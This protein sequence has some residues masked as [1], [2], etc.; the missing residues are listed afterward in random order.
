MLSRRELIVPS[1]PDELVKIGFFSPHIQHDGH[2]IYFSPRARIALGRFCQFVLDHGPFKGRVVFNDVYQITTSELA[3]WYAQEVIPEGQVFV[4]AVEQELTQRIG[5]FVHLCRIE[6]LKLKSLKNLKIGSRTISRYSEEMIPGDWLKDDIIS[7]RINE[8]FTNGFVMIGTESGTETATTEQFYFVSDQLL[9]VL[10]VHSCLLYRA[11]ILK[12]NI[13]LV[14][15]PLDGHTP[16]I[17]A[18]WKTDC[19]VPTVTYH[20][21]R[22][23]DVEIDQETLVYLQRSCFLDE[24][25]SVVEKKNRNQ[26]EEAIAR[27]IFWFGEA[28]ADGTKAGTWIKLW[29]SIESFFSVENEDIAE[30][31]SRGL[32]ALL[33]YSG[34]RIKDLD[35]YEELKRKAKR[36]YTKRGKNVHRGAFQNIDQIDLEELSTMAAWTVV[37]MVRLSLRGYTNLTEVH[38]EAHRLD[39]G[40]K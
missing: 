39:Q 13:R 2:Q 15:G 7:G 33:T 19:Q 38:R 14:R 3:D 23:Q 5:K 30:A 37:L 27:G 32:A 9:S 8:H 36:H 10:R 34:L 11:A 20:G 6:G 12:M 4:D 29:S 17:T 25:A 18:H 31:N 16:A 40:R 28:Q 26:L 35:S 21:R 24:L 1:S 22:E